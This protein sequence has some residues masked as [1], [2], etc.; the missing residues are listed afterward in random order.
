V[1]VDN[2][3]S[4]YAAYN[5]LTAEPHADGRGSIYVF[6][7]AQTGAGTSFV[8]REMALI[9]AQGLTD[10]GQVLLV[11]MDISQNSQFAYFSSLETQSRLGA[12]SGPYDACFGAT[13]FWQVT[14]SMVGENGQIISESQFMSLH[15]VQDRSLAYTCFHWENF[16][17]GHTVQLQNSRDYWNKL[18]DHFSAVFID[19]PALDRSDVLSTIV[20]EADSSILVSATSMSQDA[21]L[22]A[23]HRRIISL[24]GSCA[25]VILNDGPE[26]VAEYGGA[27]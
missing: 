15:M 24:R 12:T 2:T 27:L 8:A 4:L 16:R 23:A 7:A 19:T 10:G 18:R 17:D 11:D 20:G 13:P 3:Q 6:S 1:E 9:A 25:G 22:G 5:Q 26:R 21:G 14:P